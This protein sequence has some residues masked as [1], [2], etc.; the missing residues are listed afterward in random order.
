MFLLAVGMFFAQQAQAHTC[1][2]TPTPRPEYWPTLPMPTF[3]SST[4]CGRR[5]NFE[6][7]EYCFTVSGCF[8]VESASSTAMHVHRKIEEEYRALL[9]LTAHV[10]DQRSLVHIIETDVL[11]TWPP[12]APTPT[13]IPC[14]FSNEAD[15]L[16]EGLHEGHWQVK[17]YT[18]YGEVLND[19]VYLR[20]ADASPITHALANTIELIGSPWF[21]CESY[22]SCIKAQLTSEHQAR[23]SGPYISEVAQIDEYPDNGSAQLNWPG[24]NQAF[25]A[26]QA[27]YEESQEHRYDGACS[28]GMCGFKCLK[29]IVENRIFTAYTEYDFWVIYNDL[30]DPG[31]IAEA[32]FTAANNAGLLSPGPTSLVTPTATPVITFTPTPYWGPGDADHNRFVNVNDYRCVRDHFGGQTCGIGD[33]DGDCFVNTNDYRAVR[34]HFGQAY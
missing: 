13:A 5:K 11:P 1:T 28:Q 2:V 19:Y 20:P 21:S 16:I 8:S 27:H 30:K 12:G 33:A 34:D 25:H 9:H 18:A 14:V 23:L 17:L 15:A 24:T 6:Q 32:L 31:F 26:Y 3:S 22:Y 4:G 10:E 7:E 29:F